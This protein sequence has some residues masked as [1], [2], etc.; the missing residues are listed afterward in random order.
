VRRALA[1][2]VAALVA[3]PAA[4]AAL[5]VSTPSTASFSITLDGTDQAPTFA[6]PMTVSGA[7]TTGW[8]L[9]ATAT[10]FTSGAN[11]FPATAT[12]FTAGADDASC[13]GG[14][15]SNPTN[16][17]TWP[18]TLSATA[19]KVYNAAV[20]TGKGGN[21]VTGTFAVAVPASVFS[22]TYTSTVTITIA[23]GP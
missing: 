17:V 7:T 14:G 3:A 1:V 11:T 20:N 12:T 4:A 23:S 16:S 21:V 5:A 13:S 10:Q 22:G 6:I 18:V 9:Q 2:L 15:C 8:N 19:V